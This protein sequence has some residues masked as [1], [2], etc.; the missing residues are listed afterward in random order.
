MIFYI[1]DINYSYQ[2]LNMSMNYC[3]EA[4]YNFSK[5]D[6]IESIKILQKYQIMAIYVLLFGWNKSVS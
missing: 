4:V 6:F 3:K 1:Y 2:R 5:Q